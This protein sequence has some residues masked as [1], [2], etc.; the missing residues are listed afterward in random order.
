[1][2]RIARS[3]GA[4]DHARR[5]VLNSFPASLPGDSGLPRARLSRTA[6][7]S[8][9]LTAALA[10]LSLGFLVAMSFA[11]VVL[12]A[13]RSSV[14]TPTTQPRFFPSWMTGPLGGLWPSF[15]E[16][17]LT[18]EHF[19]SFGLLAM[20]A[21]YIVAWRWAPQLRARWTIAALVL[22]QLIFFL[23]PPLPDTDVFNY[24][25][26]ARMGVIYH[27]NPYATI[28]ALEPFTDA[29]FALSNW[30][31]LLSPYGPLFTLIMY[32]LVPFGVPASFW[33]VKLIV[34]G[35]SLG[36]LAFLWRCAVRLGRSPVRAVVFAGLNPVVLVWGLGG[37]HYDFLLMFVIMLG[38][39]LALDARA[40][41]G[42]AVAAG[43]GAP[44]ES[45]GS[46]GATPEVAARDLG[47]GAAFMS[48]VAI[49]ASAGL[50]LPI[51][52]GGVGA[53]RRRRVAVGMMASALA[54][55]LASYLAFGA[56]LPD[57]SEQSSL[58]T[59]VGPANILGMLL[60]LGGDTA[61]MR[62]VLFAVIL[63]TVALCTY[64]TWTG[65]RS[66]CAVA[67]V[68]SL[69]LVLALSWTAPWYIVWILPFA[70]LASSDRVRYAVLALSL[71]FI[72]AFS[73]MASD[74]MNLVH[75]HPGSTPLGQREG[76]LFN[77]LV[78]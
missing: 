66:W 50:L 68:A 38:V 30:H 2:A 5:V 55:A 26:Y 45:A 28:P 77:E 27:L 34:A 54:L 29:S 65:R 60:G 59:G 52:L 24:I 31:H 20:F 40:P 22:V 53:G 49:K 11:L 4:P 21:C 39:Y 32:A 36:L 10:A 69:V 41:A 12:A 43:S 42:S 15:P 8:V 76:A 25:N 48:A 7:G 71:Y 73:P 72:L 51:V 46:P 33:L 14:L 44:A 78:H 23:S 74:L 58:V 70:A 62:A 67:G 64:W 17:Y 9:R 37:D 1:M 18:P 56:R 57:L 3:G 35:S 47:V 16:S 13:Q 19:I 63:V 61:G 6:V 75:L